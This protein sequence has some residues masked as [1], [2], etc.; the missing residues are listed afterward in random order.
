MSTQS[1]FSSLLPTLEKYFGYTAFRENQREIIETILA[2]QD[3]LVLMPTGG[4]KSLCYQIPAILLGGL[5]VVVSPLISLMKDQVDALRLNGIKAAYLNSSLSPE[6]QQQVFRQLRQQELKLL[7]LAPERL[8]D[9]ENRFITF[10]KSIN[11]SLLAID[12]A[13]CISQWGHDFRP[14]YRMLADIRK[15]LDD[16][17][18][19]ALTATADP[20]TQQDILDKLQLRQPKVFISSFN[21]ENIYY[22]VAPK[23]QSY[24]QL[25]DFLAERRDQSGIIYVLSRASTEDLAERLTQDGFPAKPYHAKLASQVKEKHQDE[26]LKDEVPIVVAT[27]AFGMGIN[28][29]NVRFVVHMD[30]PKN[31]E[32]YYQETGRAGRDGL[33]SNA[34]LFYSYADVIKLQGFV[35]VAGNQEQSR[36]LR[37]KLQ[38]MAIF[39]DLRSCRR[40]FL[41]N[42]FGEEAPDYCGS[43]DV[44]R[45][46]YKTFDGTVIA[47]KALSAVARLGERFGG[48]YVIDF[49]RGSKSEKIWQEH[50]QLKTY[51][52]GADVSKK[53]W[54]RYLND[55]LRLGYLQK[56]DDKFPTLQ[57]TEQSWSVLKGQEKVTL[58]EIAEPEAITIKS[59][60]KP[61]DEHLF[62]L[63][64]GLRRQLAQDEN[65]PAYVIF[66]DATLQEMATYLPTQPEDLPHISG[67]GEVK[68][69]K[70]GS[71]F[72]DE[73]NQY[74]TEHDLDSRMSQL[75]RRSRKK[76][77]AKPKTDTKQRTYDYYQQGKTIAEIAR[78]RNLSTNTIST[79]LAY[80]VQNGSVDVTKLVDPATITKIEDAIY[81][82]GNRALKPLKDS[83]DDSISYDEIRLVIAHQ[84]R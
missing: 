10:L 44:C 73:I 32:G 77:A 46:D 13:H 82:H 65:V 31:I 14:E 53:D 70:Y 78:A 43:C 21:R 12:E 22:Q 8:I 23:R 71:A 24:A 18:T 34:L 68:I 41:L 4:G 63:L 20:V 42:Y 56:S 49:L 59:S 55:L 76:Q 28:K 74:C 16:V 11:T 79:H 47:Q 1:L 67:F 54:H 84:H 33:A 48:G 7:Y 50:K 60:A 58:V 83:L 30:L 40:K 19:V 51:G 61:M 25:L 6:E 45:N 37:E 75:R 26:F 69:A 36:V 81:V 17:P 72:L 29:S 57:L 5:T 15:A 3:T 62:S 66:S 2:G 64:K 38:Q 9:A 35:E 27:V 52:A 39:A 80:F